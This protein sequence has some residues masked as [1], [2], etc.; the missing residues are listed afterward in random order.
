MP[1]IKLLDLQIEENLQ[2]MQIL[3][4]KGEFVNCIL[5]EL[6]TNRLIHERNYTEITKRLD[7]ILKND[8]NLAKI[9]KKLEVLEEKIDKLAEKKG[10]WSKF[11][12]ILKK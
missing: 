5:I 1:A 9:N 10:F 7:K 4:H 8:V 3:S 6:E 11:K 2:Q 12:S